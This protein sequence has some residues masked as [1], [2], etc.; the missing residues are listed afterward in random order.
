MKNYYRYFL[1]AFIE[2]EK[3]FQPD[4]EIESDSSKETQNILGLKIGHAH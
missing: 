4:I 3:Y 2:S 1:T